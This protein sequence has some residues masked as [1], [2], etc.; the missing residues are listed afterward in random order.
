M[1]ADVMKITGIPFLMTILKHIK[2]G[3]AGK[4]NNMNNSNIVKHFEAVIGAYVTQGFCVT[5][6]LADNQFES[7]QG[8][9]TNLHAILHI[10]SRYEH[11]PEVKR[12][13][14]TVKERV[15][16]NHAMLPFKHLPL[17]FIIEMVYNAV[18]W[19][20]MFALKG[21]VSK[22]QSPSENAP[23]CKLNYNAH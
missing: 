21:G 10:T 9:L 6:F 1:S 16:G 8:D 19:R 13:N 17:V 3:T 2:F 23:D 20:N 15:R 7:M 5:I 4:L 22:T 11:V 12:Y 14:R 18:F